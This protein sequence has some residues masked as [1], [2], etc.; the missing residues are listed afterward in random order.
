M[1]I[2][3][4]Q[5]ARC[6]CTSQ[7]DFYPLPCNPSLALRTMARSGAP[8]QALSF[9]FFAT[10]AL[11]APARGRVIDV[12]TA[13]RRAPNP[14]R[15]S[16]P[17]L[18]VAMIRSGD[19][20]GDLVQNSCQQSPLWMPSSSMLRRGAINFSLYLHTPPRTGARSNVNFHPF[21]RTAHRFVFSDKL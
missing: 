21:L 10:T 11:S 3:L 6:V 12:V 17:L 9:P 20:V 2:L 14:P 7:C 15:H 4:R 16:F 1:G 18:V 19:C 13:F 8:G 5:F